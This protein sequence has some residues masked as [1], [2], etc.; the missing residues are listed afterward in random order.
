M[1][2]CVSRGSEN[3]IV[4]FGF[5]VLSVFSKYYLVTRAPPVRRIVHRQYSVLLMAELDNRESAG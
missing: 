2:D 1:R 5:E 4:Q 3:R